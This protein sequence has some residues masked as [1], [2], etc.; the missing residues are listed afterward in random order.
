MPVS[1]AWKKWSPPVSDEKRVEVQTEGHS[2]TVVGGEGG[3]WWVKYAMQAGFMFVLIMVLWGVYDLLK[4]KLPT[5]AEPVGEIASVVVE[6]ERHLEISAQAAQKQAAATERLTLAA[7]KQAT[8]A[9]TQA[10]AIA[11]WVDLQD[12]RRLTDLR[13]TNE[14]TP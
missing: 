8:A 4:N 12:L 6:A 9:E 11:R 14:P 7:E 1:S 3:P 10:R 5:V 2:R 13:L